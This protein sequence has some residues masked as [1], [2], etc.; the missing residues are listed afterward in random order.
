MSTDKRYMWSLAISWTAFLA[1]MLLAVQIGL[2]QSSEDAYQT[3]RFNVSG[4]VS[5]EVQTSGGSIQVEGSNDD[6]V[7]VEM[8]VRRRGKFVEAGEADLDDYEISITQNGNTVSAIADRKSNRGWNWNDGY[9]ISFVVYTPKETRTRLKTSGGSLTARNLAGSQELRTSGGSITTEGIQGQM[10]LRT[11]GGSISITDVQGDAEAKT[12][13][14]TIRADMVVGNLDANTSGGSIRLTGI[15]GNVEAKTSGGSISA[16]ILAPRD[17]IDLRT[18]GG[19][20]TVTVPDS[21]GYDLDLDANRVYAELINFN[22][23]AER[24]EIRGTF[25]GGGT[26]LKAKTSGGSIRLKYL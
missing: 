13:G 8:Y 17:I 22:G 2:A 10:V 14:G 23:R 3:E 12:S 5:L 6:E 18:S 16:E 1:L 20:I 7:L 15:E 4:S 19:S 24:D 11:S 25:N 21:Q 9:S 26:M